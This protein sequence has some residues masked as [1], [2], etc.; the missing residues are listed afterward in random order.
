MSWTINNQDVLE[1]AAEY[2][3]PKFHALLCDPPYH[4]YEPRTK[5]PAGEWNG[6]REDPFQRVKGGGFMGKKWDG[7]DVSFQPETWAALA[8]HLHPGAFGMAFGG[9]RTWHRIAVAIEDA[10]LRIH[11]TIFCWATGQSFP[12]ATR[13]GR[14]GDHPAFEGHRYGLQALK[15]AI[16]PIIV[17]QKPYEGKP[18]D[19]ITE[20]GA[21]ALW[22]D[23]G[24]IGIVSGDKRGEGGRNHMPQANSAIFGGAVGSKMLPEGVGRW[25]SNFVLVHDPECRRV[26]T[27]RVK[28]GVWGAAQNTQCGSGGTMGNGWAQRPS[29]D[30]G[31]ADADG[32]ETVD[33]WDCTP[34]C[35]VRRL[36]EQSG[37]QSGG[38]AIRRNH[39]NPYGSKRTWSVSETPAQNTVG[40]TDT[41]TAARFFHQSDW[42]YEVAEQ[43]AASDPVRYQAKAARKERDA[44]LEG[45]NIHPTCKPIK[46]IEYLATL[47]LPPDIYD[48]RILV[49]FCGVSSEMIGCGLAGWEHVEGIEG[50]AEYCDIGEARLAHWLKQPVL[51][52]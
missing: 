30:P 37:E 15:P 27:K 31:I 41:G 49:P 52:R 28:A 6:T 1:W 29:N 44:G 42:S 18:V 45:R 23:G 5:R 19:C 3:G 11:P 39:K 25:P 38:S 12:K 21:G 17:F 2:D 32:L 33:E 8:E 26:G 13:I 22:I 43:I 4:L 9:S 34:T 10:G 14:N 48:R 46:L 35:P 24:R 16:E 7:G 47:L 20:T 51:M 50:E 36:G 40:Y